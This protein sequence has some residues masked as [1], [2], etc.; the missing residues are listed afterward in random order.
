M[1]ASVCVVSGGFGDLPTRLR[2]KI[3]IDENG[4]WTWTAARDP[5][6]YGRVNW[7]RRAQFSHRLV[8]TLL[9]GPI[10]DGLVIDH[11]CRTRKCV[12]PAHLEAVTQRENIIR[13]E[14]G[15]EREK[16]LRCGHG[17]E[18]TPENTSYDKRGRRNC[19]TCKNTRAR[20]RYAERGAA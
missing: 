2:E 18:F 3:R 7:Q 13:G 1:R 19:R 15:K 11:L 14:L 8:W 9:R 17:H 12:N 20:R 6:N 10:A 4:C 16:S 5:A